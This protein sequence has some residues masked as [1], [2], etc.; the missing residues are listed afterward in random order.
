MNNVIIILIAAFVSAAV[1]IIVVLTLMQ[2][3]KNKQYKKMIDKLDYEKNQ[4][5]TSPVG[6]ELSKIEE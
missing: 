4:L 2:K 6:P 3:S 5:D 1:S